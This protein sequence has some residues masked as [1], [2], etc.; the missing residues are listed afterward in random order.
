MEKKHP[1]VADYFSKFLY[2]FPVAFAHHFKTTKHLRELFAA[3]GIPAIVMSKNGPPFNGDDFKKFSCEFDFVHSTSS[4]HFYQSNRF[5][6]AMVK[7]VKNAYK[8]NYGS[9][10]LR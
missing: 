5:I 7:K 3:E 1:I 8:K 4:P 9:Q 2:V 6:E 10:M